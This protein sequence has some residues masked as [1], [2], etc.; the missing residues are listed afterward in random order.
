MDEIKSM[1]PLQ[2]SVGKADGQEEGLFLW[3][4]QVVVVALGGLR[5]LLRHAGSFF[6]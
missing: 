5:S 1:Q 3:L 6:F 2:I 4:C